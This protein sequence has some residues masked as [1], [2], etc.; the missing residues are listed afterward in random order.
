MLRGVSRTLHQQ[1][2]V[3]EG[4]RLVNSFLQREEQ[5]SDDIGAAIDRVQLLAA[6]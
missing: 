3:P 1:A 4:A 2:E 5:V 6:W